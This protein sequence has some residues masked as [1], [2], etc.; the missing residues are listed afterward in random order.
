[1]VKLSDVLEK[2]GYDVEGKTQ[3]VS[4]SKSNIP[5]QQTDNEINASRDRKKKLEQSS[6]GWDERL[7]KATSFSRELAESF[8]MLRGKILYPGEGKDSPKTIMVASASP[9]EGK[10]FIS[11][12]LAISLAHGLDQHSLLVGCDLRRPTLAKLFGK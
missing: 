8:K 4:H 11:A 7:L 6:E 5:P 3:V 10:S 1:M 9:A 12:N 2:S